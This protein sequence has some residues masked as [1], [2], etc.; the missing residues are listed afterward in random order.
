MN[1]YNIRNA[2]SKAFAGSHQKGA[3]SLEYLMLGAVIVIIL[4][5]VIATAGDEGGIGSKIVDTFNSL[6]GNAQ[7]QVDAN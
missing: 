1:K 3:S 7:D 5:V 2:F 6:L 4:G